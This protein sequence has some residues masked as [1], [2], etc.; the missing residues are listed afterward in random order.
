MRPNEIDAIDLFRRAAF[1]KINFQV[2][3]VKNCNE[4]QLV[5]IAFNR[6]HSFAGN[7]A[8]FLNKTRHLNYNGA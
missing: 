4:N 3:L 5:Q 2:L 7:V 8:L 1:I 6:C